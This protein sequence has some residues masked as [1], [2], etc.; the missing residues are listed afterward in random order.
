MP[1]ERLRGEPVA[2]RLRESVRDRVARLD[3]PPTLGTVLASDDPS[4]ARFVELKG[5]A[6]AAAGMTHRDRRLDPEASPD[7][8]YEAVGELSRDPT[9]DA[10]FLQVPLPDGVALEAVRERIAPEK[11]VDCFHPANLGR[12]V[13]GTP[14]FRPATPAAVLRLLSA[15]DVELA[16]AAVA[17]VGRSAV[18]GRPLA[19]LL[20]AADA[21]V[22]VCHDRTA[23]LGAVTRRADV[24]VTALGEPGCIDGSM[25]A[26]GSVVVDASSIRRETDDGVEVVGDVDQSS[27]RS[28]AGALTP[29]PGGVGPVTLAA[30]LEN[31]VTA[32]ER[33]RGGPG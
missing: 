21:T 7:R 20:V 26:P 29:V 28:V 8:V 14:R 3:T 22:T 31:T 23:D 18:V 5:E 33:R 11:D 15:Y 17:V 6:A 1:A 19:N 4:D 27:A 30:L 2:K 32:A 16:G 9:V 10:V 24:V 13:A 12:L 25:L